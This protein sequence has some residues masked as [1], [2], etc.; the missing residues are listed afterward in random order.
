MSHDFKKGFVLGLVFSVLMVVLC[1]C[2]ARTIAENRRKNIGLE[3]TEELNC[4]GTGL[5]RNPRFALNV[6]AD[7]G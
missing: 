6:H 2:V 1:I 7:G 3:L 5:S 4:S